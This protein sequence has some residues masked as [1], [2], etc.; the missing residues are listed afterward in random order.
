MLKSLLSCDEQGRPFVQ[1]FNEELRNYA[2]TNKK[3]FFDLADIESHLPDG[4]PCYGI[5][6]NGN[7]VNVM[8]VC[9]E[10]VDEE[11]SGHLNAYGANHVAKAVWVMMA[12]MSGWEE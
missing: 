2:I 5:D 9:D 11:I 4:T 8:T 12:K 7:P 6:N 10:Y 3:I 1:E